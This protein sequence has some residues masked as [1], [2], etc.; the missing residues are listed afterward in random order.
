MVALLALA[1]H[2]QTPPGTV[3]ANTG[4]GVFTPPAGVPTTV[5]SNTDS[6]TVGVLRTPSTTQI[7]HYAPGA[8][9][10]FAANVGPAVC[11]T[12][13]TGAGPF[14]PA[15]NPTDLSGAPI[16]LAA[17]VD[18]LAGGAFHQGE[19]LFLRVVDSDQNLSA[20]AVESALIMVI[21]QTTGDVEVVQASET[22]PNTGEFI[23]HL[24]SGAPPPVSGDCRLSVVAGETLL[25]SYSDPADVADSS[26]S[27][28]LVDPL[29]LVFDS[30]TG[31]PVDGAQ[32]TLIES[33]SGLPATVFGDDGVSSFPATVTSGGSASDSGGT[34]YTFAPGRFRFP[35]VAPGTYRLQVV[36]P[37]T[38]AFASSVPDAALQL[39]PGAP[40]ALSAG[41]RG[42]DFVVPLGPIFQV[43]VPVDP[44]APGGSLTL[45]KRASRASAGVGEFVQYVLT[46]SAPSGSAGQP[47]LLEDRLPRGFRFERGSLRIANAPAPNPVV[48]G[49]GRS[50]SIPLGVLAPGA[51]VEVRYVARIGSGARG[52]RAI[53]L[54]LVR[55][56]ALLSNEARAVVLVVRDLMNE[57]ATLVGRVMEGSCSENLR[58]EHPGVAGVRVFLEDGTHVVTDE[59]GRF[60]FPVL[61][62]DTH[63]VQIDTQ[64]VPDGLIPAACQTNRFAG[65]AYSQFVEPQ[66]GALWR[67]D[68]FLERTP[69]G[70]GLHQQLTVTP[71]SDRQQVELRV[72]VGGAD[73]EG[74][75]GL[76]MLPSDVTPL[77]G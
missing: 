65:R 6:I 20:L 47:A 18:L 2:A 1:S 27:G 58:D 15:P 54:A 22:G 3:I 10:S 62:A 26:S 33:T 31:A 69:S 32:I 5:L 8:L 44:G 7:L 60:H 37:A 12:S 36:P 63:V 9:G 16:N 17:P 42:N 25:A 41:S 70:R 64:T 75:S 19:A 49:D 38:H 13:G 51:Q 4:Q 28:A 46:L 14:V 59:Q 23:A 48:S 66:R 57:R 77:P 52:G 67:T 21:S 73:L 74:V 71:A 68:F 34:N 56:G 39:L 72:S 30:A 24:M 61:S 40:F 29:G 50:L 45:T 11:S 53:N 43:D 76:V 35:F 55:A